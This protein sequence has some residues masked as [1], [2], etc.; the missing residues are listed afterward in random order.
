MVRTESS[1]HP[2]KNYY[3]ILLI[4]L[5]L[6]LERNVQKPDKSPSKFVSDKKIFISTGEFNE[7]F[8][9]PNKAM[10]LSSMQIIGEKGGTF[11][12][13]ELDLLPEEEVKEREEKE[14]KERDK[15]IQLRKKF[16]EQKSRIDFNF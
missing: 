9:P 13:T 7:M 2:T 14:K 1:F 8:D 11:R 12:D 4:N 10:K 5:I 15:I 6:D 3:R 16:L